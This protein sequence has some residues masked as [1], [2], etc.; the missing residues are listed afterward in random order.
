[1]LVAEKLAAGVRGKKRLVIDENK[2]VQPAIVM[3]I[4]ANTRMV[5]N[6]RYRARG[7]V[8][9]DASRSATTTV[10][11]QEFA[12][13]SVFWYL[14]ADLSQAIVPRIVNQKVKLDTEQSFVR[15]SLHTAMSQLASLAGVE[16]IQLQNLD[17]DE[18]FVSAAA[19]L[20]NTDLVTAP[21]K[22]SLFF[23]AQSRLSK[24]KAEH[25]L[26]YY[27]DKPPD[28]VEKE[29]EDDPTA[30]RIDLN[31]AAS[32]MASTGL[33]VMTPSIESAINHIL[34]LSGFDV[35]LD[36]DQIEQLEDFWLNTLKDDAERKKNWIESSFKVK[37][38]EVAEAK[39]EQWLN[40]L[41]EDDANRLSEI[42]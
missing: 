12:M 17:L 18:A 34:S 10:N 7:R 13:K 22:L 2:E 5:Y 1:V 32:I 4:A 35:F 28:L 27:D 3:D 31:L 19:W 36:I 15:K 33:P 40:L 38:K 42:A 26:D 37:S 14:M 30:V 8:Y 41:T 23:D 24:Y 20:R 25:L 29:E 9:R 6:Q 39:A 21:I 11:V 16:T